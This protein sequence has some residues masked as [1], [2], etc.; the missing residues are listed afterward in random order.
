MSD[1][2]SQTDTLRLALRGMPTL[3]DQQAYL[4]KFNMTMLGEMALAAEIDKPAHA[5]NGLVDQIIA[6]L[7]S[8]DVAST[9]QGVLSVG[10]RKRGAPLPAK[11]ASYRPDELWLIISGWEID[12]GLDEDARAA[13]SED[14]LREYIGYLWDSREL[15]VPPKQWQT[16]TQYYRGDSE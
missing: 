8:G 10:E 4:R 16:L 11:V 13:Y 14:D 15:G 7:L 12:Q 3:A 5:K 9:D 6:K 2:L 1:E